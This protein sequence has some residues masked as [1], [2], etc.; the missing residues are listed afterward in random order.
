MTT[1]EIY[2]D[3]NNNTKTDLKEIWH[4]LESSDSVLGSKQ[5]LVNMIM[6]IQVPSKAQNFFSR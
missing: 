5:A 3:V 6:N 4:G 2:V 1:R